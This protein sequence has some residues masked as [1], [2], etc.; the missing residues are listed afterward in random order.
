MSKSFATAIVTVLFYGV[1]LSAPQPAATPAAR[2]RE[3]K[4]QNLL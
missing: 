4:L 3:R 2:A 1:V